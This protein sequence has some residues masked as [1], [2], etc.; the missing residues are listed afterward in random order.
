LLYRRNFDIELL[1]FI[2]LLLSFTQYRILVVTKVRRKVKTSRYI[3]AS[4]RS[5]ELLHSIYTDSD[6]N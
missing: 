4:K 5:M 6:L 2:L 1:L 3:F